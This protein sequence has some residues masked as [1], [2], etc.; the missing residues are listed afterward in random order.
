MSDGQNFHGFKLDDNPIFNK[1]V[2]LKDAD[3]D[4]VVD[5]RKYF[6]AFE[7]DP[8]LAQFNQERVRIYRFNKAASQGAMSL[9]RKSDHSLGKRLVR[10]PRIFQLL[11]HSVNSVVSR[12]S[13]KPQSY[14]PSS[15]SARWG[16]RA[17]WKSSLIMMTGAVPQLAMHSTNSTAYFPSGLLAMP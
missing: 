15:S 4:V 9:H 14:F 8:C 2:R 10:F 3:L 12:N 7:D 5:N 17:S 16:V 6:F 11:N 13:V 1:Q